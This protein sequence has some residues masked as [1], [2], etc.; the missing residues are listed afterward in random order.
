MA[1]K[2]KGDSA[3]G[4]FGEGQPPRMTKAEWLRREQTKVTLTKSDLDYIA[5]MMGIGRQVLR[6]NRPV[7]RKL[8]AAMSRLGVSTSGL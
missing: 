1:E 2:N 8:K 3:K 4:V 6:D 5:Q 7:S